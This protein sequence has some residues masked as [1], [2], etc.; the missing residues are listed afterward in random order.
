MQQACSEISFIVV[1]ALRRPRFVALGA[2]VH[3]AECGLHVIRFA[4]TEQLIM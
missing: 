2:I 3:C 4:C 1:G